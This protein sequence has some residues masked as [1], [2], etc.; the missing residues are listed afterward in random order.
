MQL[1]ANEC[2]MQFLAAPFSH[3]PNAWA[4]GYL[5]DRLLERP[6]FRATNMIFAK[7]FEPIYHVISGAACKRI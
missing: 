2:L 1:I 4:A 5:V 3:L 6:R 7:F